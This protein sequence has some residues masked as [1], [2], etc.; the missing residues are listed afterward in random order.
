MTCSCNKK[1]EEHQKEKC[2][3]SVLDVFDEMSCGFKSRF[4]GGNQGIVK[5]TTHAA[6]DAAFKFGK[7]NLNNLIAKYVPDYVIE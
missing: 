1:H 2:V 4:E 7:C 3:M 6:L 5:S